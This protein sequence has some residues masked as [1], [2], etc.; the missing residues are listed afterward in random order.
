MRTGTIVKINLIKERE[1]ER[2]RDHFNYMI[3]LKKFL[4]DTLY[5]CWK[6]EVKT[7]CYRWVGI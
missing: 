4:F 1:R 3:E 7:K 6:L 5:I 2:E